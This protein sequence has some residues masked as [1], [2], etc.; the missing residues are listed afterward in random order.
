MYI[1]HPDVNVASGFRHGSCRYR[2]LL[3]QRFGAK[4]AIFA[5]LLAIVILCNQCIYASM[6]RIYL[7]SCYSIDS[8]SLQMYY[9]VTRTAVSL[10]LEL[11]V[12]SESTRFSQLCGCIPYA[13]IH[14]FG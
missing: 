4:P 2:I 1:V 8:S 7:E 6:Q 13:A 9:D 11:G 5:F 10:G 14:C 12:D 3:A